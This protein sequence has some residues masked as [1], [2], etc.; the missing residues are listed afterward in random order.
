MKNSIVDDYPY[1][2]INHHSLSDLM[3]Y[4]KSNAE[5]DFH[6]N[7]LVLSLFHLNLYSLL[8]YFK[9]LVRIGNYNF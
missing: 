9:N 1:S 3:P 6:N 5:H 7:L 2:N 8:K 4:A